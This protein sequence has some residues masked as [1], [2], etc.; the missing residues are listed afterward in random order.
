MNYFSR[1]QWTIIFGIWTLV[2]LF[3]AT[4]TY[5]SVPDD[6]Y[7]K[8]WIKLLL[9]NIPTWY[10]WALFTPFIIIAVDKYPLLTEKWFKH[11][12]VH[13]AIGVAS[14]FVLSNY[15]VIISSLYW[16]YFDIQ[17]VSLVDYSAYFRNRFLNDIPFYSVLVAILS[18]WRAHQARQQQDLFNA[19]IKLK[20]NMLESELK[21]AQ[22]MALRLQL[23]PHFLF[24]S[25]HTISYLIETGNKEQAVT[26]TT[27][28]GDFL[29]RA[30][31]FEK[32]PLI[33]LE[34]E[35]EFFNL[36]LNIEQ[37]RFKDRLHIFYNIE[38]EAKR[39]VVP[40]LILQPLIENAIKHGISKQEVANTICLDVSLLDDRLVIDLYNDG[41][42]IKSPDVLNKEESIGLNNVQ[43]R[44]QQ[45][46]GDDFIFSVENSKDL[47]GVISRLNIPVKVTLSS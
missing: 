28:L 13:I 31:A 8:D 43:N 27:R 17:E 1:K 19:E 6:D 9:F 15:R 11:L 7:H 34:K 47:K 4:N 12:L 26:M 35:L 39:I 42:Q 33:T 25:L 45:V 23:S 20:N 30:L 44:L 46:Y 32:Q 2:A 38:E 41:P 22:L 24:N 3:F 40:N 16:D 5:F 29:R 14:L 21:E 18:A 10:L 36:Y 37:E